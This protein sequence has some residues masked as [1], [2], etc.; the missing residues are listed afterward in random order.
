MVNTES[1]SERYYTN[2]ADIYSVLRSLQLQR[3]SINIQFDKSTSLFS[4]IILNTNLKEKF[5]ILDAFNPKVGHKLAEEG[6]SFSFLASYKGIKVNCKNLRV[7]KTL[8]ESGAPLYKIEF[9]AKLL[10]LQR[11]EAFRVHVPAALKINTTC[12]S[13]ARGQTLTGRLFNISATGFRLEFSGRLEPEISL[14]EMFNT[15]ISGLPDDSSIQCN[16][17][18]VH[19]EYDEEKDKTICGCHYDE[20]ERP[21]QR[22]IDHF[23]NFLQREER[24][25][26]AG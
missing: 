18:V 20:L 25:H 21:Q 15:R 3:S 6:K 11:R 24:L 14:M 2:A 10:Y 1:D 9:P 4:S 5:F 8:E 26:A 7:K 23:V 12:S 17:T 13:E 16:T 22:I 19:I